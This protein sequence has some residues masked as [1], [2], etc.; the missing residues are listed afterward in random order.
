MADIELVNAGNGRNRL[1][2]AI[3]QAMA[4]IDTQIEAAGQDAGRLNLVEFFI[5]RLGT[6]G[7]AV[8]A[9]VNFDKVGANLSGRLNLVGIGVNEQADDNAMLLKA[10]NCILDCFPLKDFSLREQKIIFTSFKPKD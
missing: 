7:V 8:A 5:L 1:H 9:G 10:A 6:P 2:V 3:I 4:G